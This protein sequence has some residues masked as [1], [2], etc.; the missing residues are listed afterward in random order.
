[1]RRVILVL[2]LFVAACSSPQPEIAVSGESAVVA[3]AV[4]AY[5]VFPSQL[6]ANPAPPPTTTTTTTT[7][8]VPPT[9][10]ASDSRSEQAFE[11]PVSYQAESPCGGWRDLIT[12][13]FGA[14]TPTACR[15][16]MCESG[17]DPYAVNDDPRYYAAGLFQI[18]KQW[19]NR[20]QQITGLP[21]YD[22]RFD[23][24]ANVMF[25]AY[26]VREEGWASQFDCY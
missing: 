13:H 11:R 1:M 18:I 8:S 14:D 3:A 26:L 9:T 25:A 19:A 7:S 6:L 4:P 17:G 12:A 22:G 10:A 5:A 23:P 15:V 2:A 24:N 21:Y 16:M 20:F